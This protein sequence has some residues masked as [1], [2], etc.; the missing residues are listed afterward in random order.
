M[1]SFTGVEIYGKLGCFYAVICPLS[2]HHSGL[3]TVEWKDV[4]VPGC[5]HAY[6]TFWLALLN[7]AVTARPAGVPTYTLITAYTLFNV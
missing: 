1:W 5:P 2:C 6:V 4:D 3:L 7:Y